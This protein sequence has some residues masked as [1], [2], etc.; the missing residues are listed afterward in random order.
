MLTVKIILGVVLVGALLNVLDII[1]AG[2]KYCI[3]YIK[4]SKITSNED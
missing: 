1:E 3:T 4:Q 2:A